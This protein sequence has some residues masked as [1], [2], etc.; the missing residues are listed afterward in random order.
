MR[1]TR[2]PAE[3]VDLLEHVSSHIE[4]ADQE[5]KT[6]LESLMEDVEELGFPDFDAEYNKRLYER[7]ENSLKVS[8]ICL[9]WFKKASEAEKKDCLCEFTKT[10]FSHHHD[11]SDRMTSRGGIDNNG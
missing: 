1:K 10:T 4:D 2:T 6:L 11:D 7:A 9:E 5:F 3:R 8:L